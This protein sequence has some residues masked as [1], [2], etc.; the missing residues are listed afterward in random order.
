[1]NNMINICNHNLCLNQDPA[2]PMT[3]QCFSNTPDYSEQKKNQINGIIQ[4]I[5]DNIDNLDLGLI[6]SIIGLMMDIECNNTKIREFLDNLRPRNTMGNFK[7]IYVIDFPNILYYIIDNIRQRNNVHPILSQQIIINRAIQSIKDF[8]QRELENNNYIIIIFKPSHNLNIQLNMYDNFKDIFFGDGAVDTG[9]L[10]ETNEPNDI[11]KNLLN[12]TFF[13]I[14]CQNT[15]GTPI[16]PSNYDDFIFWIVSVSLF[17]ILH[18]NGLDVQQLNLLTLDR[19]S[20]D[21]QQFAGTNIKNIFF[22]NNVNIQHI[23]YIKNTDGA[24]QIITN[25]NNNSILIQYIGV[26]HEILNSF[27]KV[28]GNNPINIELCNTD[29]IFNELY[30]NMVNY[31]PDIGQ[32]TIYDYIEYCYRTK[33]SLNMFENN[34][35]NDYRGGMLF[36][37][38]IKYI[39]V[40]L[41]QDQIINPWIPNIH[42]NRDCVINN[43]ILDNLFGL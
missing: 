40:T 12:D 4:G 9:Y 25:M 17:N 42:C 30:I 16:V 18:F 7:Q 2:H 32:T 36:Y 22:F 6:E 35:I 31:D 19:Q 3:P 26:C 11:F 37:G 13:I 15:L 29:D 8:C 14:N 41:Y 43:S 1:M 23:E 10:M 20:L 28:N 27:N 24:I 38:L 21:D 34:N 39:Q 5:Y 33:K